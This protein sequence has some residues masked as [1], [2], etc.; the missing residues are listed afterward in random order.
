MTM[1]IVPA[2]DQDLELISALI[3][4]EFPYTQAT[5]E[6]LRER[7]GKQRLFLFKQAEGKE[8]VG[9]IEVEALNMARARIN[10]LVVREEFRGK[11]NAR[12]LVKFAMD[13]IKKQGFKE[14]TLLVRKSN[15]AAKKLYGDY[16]F[17]FLRPHA[18]KLVDEPTEE[19]YLGLFEGPPQGVA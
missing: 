10:G 17:R 8:L 13:F 2:E 15:E 4:K 7:L 1:T 16:G 19:W 3:K 9:F 14:I 12:A 5:P 18:A 11:G 6:K